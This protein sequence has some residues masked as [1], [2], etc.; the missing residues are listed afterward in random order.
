ML[1]AEAQANHGGDREALLAAINEAASNIKNKGGPASTQ[2][3]ALMKSS[4]VNARVQR[5]LISNAG[6]RVGDMGDFAGGPRPAAAEHFEHGKTLLNNRAGLDDQSR[7]VEEDLRSIRSEYDYGSK[8]KFVDV[9]GNVSTQTKLRNMRAQH[10][11]AMAE[12]GPASM[13][14][15]YKSYKSQLLSK[16]SK[17][18]GFSRRPVGLQYGDV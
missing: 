6:S 4:Q 13:K 14:G 3:Q 10:E 11:I 15:S 18:S 12:G 16:K 9:L 7:Q 5:D 1:L 8:R 17:S 2:G